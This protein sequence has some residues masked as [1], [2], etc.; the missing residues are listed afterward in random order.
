LVEA[1]CPNPLPLTEAPQG[2][3]PLSKTDNDNA[4]APKKGT[5]RR[6]G[7]E[8]WTISTQGNLPSSFTPCPGLTTYNDTPLLLLLL[9]LLQL[10][11]GKDHANPVAAHSQRA[12]LGSCDFVPF[13]SPVSQVRCI[14]SP[15]TLALS[16]F[17]SHLPCL[18]GYMTLSPAS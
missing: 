7:I 15:T 1:K 8:T 18:S 16:L 9:V 5:M 10:Y 4:I 17:C 12:N 3:R 11:W 2:H 13:R 14:T 6:A